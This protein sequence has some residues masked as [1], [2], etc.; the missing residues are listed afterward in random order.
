MQRA[1]LLDDEDIERTILETIL[2]EADFLVCASSIS[3][4][5]SLSGCSSFDVAILDLSV[6]GQ[7][8]WQVLELC[9]ALADTAILVMTDNEIIEHA[10]RVNA[11]TIA[12]DYIKKP[13]SKEEFLAAVDRTIQ[14]ARV[15]RENRALKEQQ[16]IRVPHQS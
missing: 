6:S 15:V 8:K 13:F 1:L 3:M 16:P 9:N 7:I 14:H 10:L 5:L 11:I 4:A 12:V 2:T